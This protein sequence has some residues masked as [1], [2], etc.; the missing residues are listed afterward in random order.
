MAGDVQ[1]TA[2]RLKDEVADAGEIHEFAATSL[3]EVDAKEEEEGAKDE[4][5]PASQN[6]MSKS[7]QKK[8]KRKQEW[9][10]GR[11]ARKV[12]RREKLKA[13]KMRKREELEN[14]RDSSEALSG[15]PKADRDVQHQK[16]VQVPVT[17]VIDCQFDDL[18]FEKEMISLG[19]QITRTYSDNKKSQVRAHI[20]ISSF[21]GRLKERFEGL[22]VKQY[23][24]W[25]GVRFRESSFVDVAK[26]A[27][28]WMTSANGGQIAGA[29]STSQQETE[30]EAGGDADAAAEESDKAGEVVYL[31][32]ESPNTL[33]ALK[34]YSTYVVGGLVD[35]NRHKGLCYK[36]A[37]DC[38]FKTAKLPISDYMNMRTRS[39]LATNHV[40]EI[41]LNWLVSGDWAD[42]FTKV[43]PKRKGGTVRTQSTDN[44]RDQPKPHRE[45]SGSDE[46][47]GGVSI[48]A[49]R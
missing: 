19:S 9:E 25:R 26:E 47:K 2:K 17:F 4:T 23:Q 16:A 30:A 7:Q 13:K 41:M 48:E 6:P 44:T 36:R 45:S 37:L 29:L 27:R 28:E 38:G 32:S 49:E 31:T 20:A 43:M 5:F 8:L 15:P 34:P 18:M 11:D 21:S 3:A 35:K 14:Q 10:D 33:Q 22:L 39:V 12:L 46:S 24:S 42:A 1:D 40:V